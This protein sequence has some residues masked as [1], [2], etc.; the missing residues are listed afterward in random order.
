MWSMLGAHT[1]WTCMR[2]LEGHGH[3][4]HGVAFS[5]DGRLLASASADRTVR[6]WGPS[7][8]RCLR[9]LEGHTDTVLAVAFGP[10]G[11]VLASAGWDQSIRLWDSASGQ[12]TGVLEGLS[13]IHISEPT[14]P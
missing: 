4:V 9:T 14:R 1:K 12:C 2:T 5:P 3:W 10:D 11:K 8:G 7:S 6:L 13:L